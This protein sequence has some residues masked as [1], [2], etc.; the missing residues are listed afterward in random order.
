MKNVKK[1]FLLSTALTLFAAPAAASSFDCAECRPMTANTNMMGNPNMANAMA[2]FSAASMIGSGMAAPVAAVS[3][4]RAFDQMP[5]I[6]KSRSGLNYNPQI[7]Q[8]NA[9]GIN[10]APGQDLPFALKPSWSLIDYSKPQTFD[11]PQYSTENLMAG[12]EQKQAEIEKNGGWKLD[13]AA[14]PTPFLV[15]RK[16][17]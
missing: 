4:A 13:W 6:Y 7:P 9:S 16:V 14:K 2:A 11:L 12:Y 3:A 15:E 10:W 5:S 8:S 17:Y 1:I